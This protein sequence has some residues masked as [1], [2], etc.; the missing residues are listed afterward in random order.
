MVWFPQLDRVVTFYLVAQWK[1]TLNKMFLLSVDMQKEYH[2]PL[3]VTH[4]TICS[5]HHQ[6]VNSIYERYCSIWLV[7]IVYITKIIPPPLHFPTFVNF[8]EIYLVSCKSSYKV[9]RFSWREITP[10]NVVRS[11][12]RV[13]FIKG[14][15]SFKINEI[16]INIEVLM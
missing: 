3:S 9:G 16:Y 6:L 15:N 2:S 14:N 1:S 10:S 12:C 13:I 7:D 11:N 4:D 5:T 8:W